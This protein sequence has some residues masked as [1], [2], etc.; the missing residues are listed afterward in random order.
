M[1]SPSH[2]G[3]VGDLSP[4]GKTDGNLR[5][6][7][8]VHFF[9]R[10]IVHEAMA[11][12]R[13]HKGRSHSMA[14]QSMPTVSHFLNGVGDENLRSYTSVVMA[15]ESFHVKQS[16]VVAYLCHGR[17]ETLALRVSTAFMASMDLFSKLISTPAICI[18]QLP[19]TSPPR[20][21]SLCSSSRPFRHPW[22]R[23]RR[24]YCADPMPG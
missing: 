14:M 21:N 15:R 7:L 19:H 10:Q 5:R 11:Q 22:K 3:H 23:P 13:W 17:S 16:G 1:P 18:R 2:D 4:A 9:Y 6:A 20:P 8:R 24:I 12:L